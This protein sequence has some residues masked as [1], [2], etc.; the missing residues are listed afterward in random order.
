M[1]ILLGL[2]GCMHEVKVIVIVL[3]GADVVVVVFL[4]EWTC[5]EM[6]VR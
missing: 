2:V 5:K 6:S 1:R 3:D 4:K